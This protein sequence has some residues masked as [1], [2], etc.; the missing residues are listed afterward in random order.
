MLSL[1]HSLGEGFHLYQYQVVKIRENL[2]NYPSNPWIG[3]I[4]VKRIALCKKPL[5]GEYT[6]F[7]ILN[8]V[9][10]SN[11]TQT[12][13]VDCSTLRVIVYLPQKNRS[14]ALKG[15]RGLVFSC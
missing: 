9:F 3:L 4:S 13:M 7:R 10:G 2:A 6:Q 14:S 1:E 5:I 8:P 11:A 12:P 15:S